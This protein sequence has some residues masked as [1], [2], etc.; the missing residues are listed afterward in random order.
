MNRSDSNKIIGIFDLMRTDGSVGNLII[1][2]EELA[3]RCKEL[4]N[5]FGIFDADILILKDTS[6]I[7]NDSDD[8]DFNNN[9]DTKTTLIQTIA[10]AMGVISTCHDFTSAK[11]TDF[12]ELLTKCVLWPDPESILCESHNYDTTQRIQAYYRRVGS[13]PKLF[14]KSALLIRAEC[15]VA[16]KAAGSLTVAV[17][18]KQNPNSVGQSNANLSA[19]YTFFQRAADRYRAHFFLIG[20]E[21]SN[22]IFSDLKNVSITHKDGFAIDGQL[23]LIQVCQLFMGMMSGPSNM[24]LFGD[25]PYLIFK[26][27]D[28]HSTEMKSEIGDNDQY[29]FGIGHQKV[30][31]I[32]DTVDSITYAF[33]MVVQH[34]N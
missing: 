17:H 31:R 1:L 3:I 11:F 10:N 26:N 30:L 14:V 22:A 20:N 8:I 21:E 23:G 33:E 6:Q 9:N 5:E 2:V 13:I 24:A 25:N 16:D 18:L 34:I 27:P 12:Q 32:L 29:P 4:E 7:F 28:H 15:Y 19:W